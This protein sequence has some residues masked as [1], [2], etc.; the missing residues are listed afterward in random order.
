MARQ[1]PPA[2]EKRDP[3]VARSGGEAPPTPRARRWRRCPRPWT[4]LPQSG[5]IKGC[6]KSKRD[7]RE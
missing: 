4:S 6:A 1:R 7:D 3:N 2:R 5:H